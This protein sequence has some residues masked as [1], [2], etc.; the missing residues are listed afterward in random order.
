M[1]GY[2]GGESYGGWII[3]PDASTTSH[4]TGVELGLTTSGAIYTLNIL[5]DGVTRPPEPNGGCSSLSG[6]KETLSIPAGDRVTKV[7]VWEGASKSW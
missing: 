1:W 6:T 3:I 7:E 5:G 2:H 4:V